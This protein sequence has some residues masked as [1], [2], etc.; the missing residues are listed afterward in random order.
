MTE[1][2]SKK[3]VSRAGMLGRHYRNQQCLLCVITQTS[4][5]QHHARFVALATANDDYSR[6]TSVA[7]TE[8]RIG[9]I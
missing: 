7:E 8:H 2:E 3:A 4:V 9:D 6:W 1:R 5:A